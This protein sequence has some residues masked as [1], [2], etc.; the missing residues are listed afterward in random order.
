MIFYA[1][2]RGNADELAK[3]LLN[4]EEN[5]HVTVHDIRGFVADDLAGAL[6]EAYAISKG[7]RCKQ[8]LFSLSLNPP[9]YADVSLEDFEAAIEEIERKL[10]LL[11]QPRVVVFHEKKGRRHCHAVWL[12]LKASDFN[13]RRMVGVQMAH[14]KYKLMDVSRALFRKYGWAMPKGMERKQ[15]K[16]PYNLSREEYR[17][18]AKLAEDPQALKIFFKQSWER[19]DSKQTFARFLSENGFFLAQGDRR[20]YVAVDLGGKVY[21]LSKWIDI[22]T[23]DL[24]ARLGPHEQLPTTEKARAFIAE[25]M[26]DSLKRHMEDLKAEAKQKRLPIVQEIRLMTAHH[27]KDRADLIYRQEQ[28]HKEETKVRVARFA[29]GVAGIW[30]R[31]TGEY[32]KKCALNMAEIKSCFDRDRKELHALVRSQLIERQGLEKT[33]KFYREEH[34]IEVFRLRQEIARYL[35]TATEPPKPAAQAVAGKQPLAA[36]LARLEGKISLLTADMLRQELARYTPAA[37]EALPPAVAKAESAATVEELP[38][39]AQLAQVETRLAL[40]TCDLSKMQAAL[41]SNL[42][43]NEMRGRIRRLIEKTLETLQLKAVETK[44]EEQRLQEKSREYQQKQAE[45]N[46]YVRQFAILQMKV[47]EENRRQAANRDFLS[48]I[49]NMAYALNGLPNWSI[50]VMSPPPDKRLDEREYI[51]NVVIKRDTAQLLD[52]VFR[53]PENESLVSRRPPIDPKTAVPALRRNV[54]EVREMMTRAGLRPSG[55]GGISAVAP[56][57]IRMTAPPPLRAAIKFNAKR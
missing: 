54:L 39:A 12:R 9:E 43:S 44:T 53:S 17:Q 4:A 47:E 48:V 25:R 38:P 6:M 19:T 10:G 23:R 37:A 50:S 14:F 8:F 27:R 51:Q 26:T 3:H 30:E 24:K 36:Q 49:T 42:I 56:A 1:S 29:T 55:G 28:R 7:S 35:S 20:G 34:R 21:S 52:R 31:A 46:E 13:P 45:F 11:N 57:T 15:D 32:K 33:V 16:N 5:E 41:E 40:L 18:A 22:P 2:V